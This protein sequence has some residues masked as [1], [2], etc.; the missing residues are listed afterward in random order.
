MGSRA[1]ARAA[2]VALHK[3]GDLDKAAR[4]YASY[5]AQVPG[6]AGVWSNLGALH[7]AKG[8][9]DMAL[10]AHRRANALAPDDNG[11]RNN[12]ANVLSDIGDYDG[13]LELRRRILL[14][15]P[16]AKN[17]LAMIGRCLRGKG[18]Y[19]AAIKHL[20]KAIEVYPDDAELQVQLSFAL[21]GSG[22]YLTGFS[23]YQARWQA[24]ELTPRDLDYPQ[25]QGEPLEGKSIS[26]L[27]EQGFGDAVLFLRFLPLLK[28]MGAHVRLVVEGPMH[29]LFEGAVGAD[30][31]VRVDQMG[32]ATDYWVNL[33]DLTI[34]YFA[35]QSDV[36]APA[37]LTMP[38]DAKVRAERITAPFSNSTKVGVVWSGSATYKANAFRSFSHSDLLPLSD[39]KG[40]Q[41][42]SLY[43]GP[44][45][46]GF[47]ADGADGI[48][49]DAASSDRDFADCAAMIQE[50]DLVITSDTVTAHIA[51]SLGVPTWVLLHWDPF[52]VWKHQGDTT[53]W[54]PS[55]RCFRQK[56]ARDWQSVLDEVYNALI[57]FRGKSL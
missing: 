54:Y 31:I 4:A 21:L 14:E 55:I 36:P 33:I 15:D 6:D 10:R 44:Y 5:L 47:Y 19:V 49:V 32:D 3:K 28:E 7:R 29:R 51:G 50:M 42:F 52:W 56:T 17:H 12:L 9:Y 11:L 1:Q 57:S 23:A 8:R 22:D 38:K 40:N 35:S 45:L 53:P 16:T 46:D 43:K 18:E 20:E 13:S 30:E 26:V 27:P 37:L 34:P 2:A 41:L 25:W 48:I 24:G 39:V